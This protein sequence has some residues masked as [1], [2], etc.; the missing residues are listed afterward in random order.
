MEEKTQNDMFSSLK[1]L[2]LLDLIVDIENSP[3]EYRK[4]LGLAKN[5]TFGIEIEYERMFRQ[6]VSIFIRDNFQS[7][8]SKEDES[9]LFGGEITSPIMQ[10]EEEKWEELRKICN[11]LKRRKV[12]TK[13][14]AG[15]HIHV[16]AHIL[17]NDCDNWRRFLK[18]YSVYEDVLFRFLYG[19]K[20]TGRKKINEYARPTA[21]LILKNIDRINQANSISDLKAELPIE[22]RYQSLNLTNTHFDDLTDRII[23]K[24]T[25]EFR[26]PNSTTEE[27][28]WQNNINALVKLMI[29]SKSSSIDEE[30][31]DFII[32]KDS[33]VYKK[34]A[35]D[36]VRLKK[37]LEFV[38]LI[39]D[40]NID[41]IY[42]LKQY[43]KEF[44]SY[45]NWN[46][47]LKTKKFLKLY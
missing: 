25:V 47:G 34:Y 17:E 24:N 41:K 33:F 44:E 18:I 43:L 9:L 38:D 45:E 2:E 13:Y 8:H 16:G 27:I 30:Y 36:E 35:Y 31:L 12:V 29:A 22:D 26:S 28:V 42:F 7:W 19:D 5:I 6:M 46:T 1:G 21:Q 40:N 10:D 32:N 14:N 3:L 39:F 23:N 37:V 15:G 11:Y 20:I 4:T